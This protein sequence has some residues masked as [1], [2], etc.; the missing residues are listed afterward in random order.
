[1]QSNLWLSVKSWPHSQNLRSLWPQGTE[2]HEV[3]VA[4]STVLEAENLSRPKVAFMGIY[5]ILLT[6]SFQNG[7]KYQNWTKIGEVLLHSHFKILGFSKMYLLMYWLRISY[8]PGTSI[9]CSTQ[10]QSGAKANL[11]TYVDTCRHLW[12]GGAGTDRHRIRQT[13]VKPKWK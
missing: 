1:M 11:N 7:L 3:K 6:F 4:A 13:N 8:H 5:G 12:G 2:R 9:I 10:Y